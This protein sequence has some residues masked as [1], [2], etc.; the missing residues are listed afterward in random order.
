MS[1]EDRYETAKNNFNELENKL[2]LIISKIS[3][4]YL[5]DI[6][7][8]EPGSIVEDFMKAGITRCNTVEVYKIDG[9]YIYRILNGEEPLNYFFSSNPL[10]VKEVARGNKIVNTVSTKSTFLEYSKGGLYNGVTIKLATGEKWD[11][12]KYISLNHTKTDLIP[13][14]RVKD[15]GSSL[16]V[17]GASGI[18]DYV[19]YVLSNTDRDVIKSYNTGD[20]FSYIQHLKPDRQDRI[21]HGQYLAVINKIDEVYLK[22]QKEELNNKKNILNKLLKKEP[23]SKIDA[24]SYTLK[25]KN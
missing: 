8:Y 20:I 18:G 2:K 11:T 6:Y 22:I 23:T 16:K 12:I 24:F 14:V 5:T 10:Y 15:G 7:D 25:K 1:I 3:D 19:K 9:L 21:L 4:K 13:D 17:D